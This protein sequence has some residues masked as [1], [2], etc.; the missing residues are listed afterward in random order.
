[1]AAAR[2]SAST[3]WRKHVKQDKR[4]KLKGRRNSG[5][6]EAHVRL[7]KHELTCAAYRTLS[8]DARALLVEMRALYSGGEN[9]IF[10]SV[11]DAMD[12]MGGVCQRRAQRA[13]DELLVRGWIQVL[14]PG[15]FS[16]KTPHA[17]EFALNN[18]PLT[19]APGSLATKDFMRW[20]P[21]LAVTEGAIVTAAHH[22]KAR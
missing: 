3:A 16:R 18:E 10:M 17:T 11:R 19:N 6:S 13:R 5:A 22:E 9:R 14:S 15:G 7:Y 8:T 20:Q 21:N 2:G 4:G 12:R 1:M